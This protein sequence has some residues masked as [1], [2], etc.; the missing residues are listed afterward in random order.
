MPDYFRTTQDNTQQSFVDLPKHISDQCWG[1][2]AKIG[3]ANEIHFR[4]TGDR[5]TF[6]STL[7]FFHPK[8][9]VPEIRAGENPIS[10]IESR[11]SCMCRSMQNHQILTAAGGCCNYC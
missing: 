7:G 10:P 5:N 8:I 3:L 4:E 9:W 2:L 1:R 11:K 6:K